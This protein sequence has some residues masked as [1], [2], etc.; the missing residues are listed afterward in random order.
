MQN[1]FLSQ[2]QD[3]AGDLAAA[4]SAGVASWT[5]IATANDVLQLIATCVAIVAGI[6]AVVWHRVRIAEVKRKNNEQSN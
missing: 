4:G 1:K 5:W 2:S 3:V 6:Y